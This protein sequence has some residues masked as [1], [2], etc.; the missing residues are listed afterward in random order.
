MDTRVLRRGQEG[1][2]IGGSPHALEG[3]RSLGVVA[4]ALAALRVPQL[5]ISIE[6]RGE[7]GLAV[8]RERDPAHAGSVAH[9]G[10]LYVA[11][12]VHIPDFDLSVTLHAQTHLHIHASRQQKMS[13]GR[14]EL[15]ALD[16][17]RMA[18]PTSS[19]VAS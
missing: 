4:D 19:R 17:F 8:R 7:E 2:R 5:D 14:E 9:V 12:I 18:R 6:R 11:A 3:D 13:V 10:P 1:I 16:R 15:D